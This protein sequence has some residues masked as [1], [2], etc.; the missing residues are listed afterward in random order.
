M[1]RAELRVVEKSAH[2]IQR[3]HVG[4]AGVGRR[5]QDSESAREELSKSAFDREPAIGHETYN[6]HRGTSYVSES[7]TKQRAFHAQQR[8]FYATEVA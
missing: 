8:A 2:A 4:G 7:C 3:D 1:L 6:Q 5:Q